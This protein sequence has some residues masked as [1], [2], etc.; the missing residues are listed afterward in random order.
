MKVVI[1]SACPGMC[2]SELGRQYTEN[3][4]LFRIALWLLFLLVGRSAEVGSRTYISAVTRN[5]EGQGKL[6]KNDKYFYGGE[7]IETAE[8]RK[9]GG[10]I[11]KEMTDVVEKADPKVKGIMAAK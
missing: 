1:N 7:M 9:F 4:I 10:K 5:V 3:N 6:W 11:W 8:G 2:K